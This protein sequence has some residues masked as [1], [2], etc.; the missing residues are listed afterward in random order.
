MN[1]EKFLASL[2]EMIMN[3]KIVYRIAG[4]I[5]FIAGLDRYHN[6]LDGKWGTSVT[7]KAAIFFSFFGIVLFICSFFIKNNSDKKR[8]K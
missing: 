1:W 7:P 5:G 2:E 4:I 6:G 3:E 8:K